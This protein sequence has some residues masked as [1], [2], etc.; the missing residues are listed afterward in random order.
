MVTAHPYN[1][2]PLHIKFFTR[3]SKKA[4]DE[5]TVSQSLPAGMT[6]AEEY[7]GVDGRSGL[8]GSGRVGPVDI[9]DGRVCVGH[10][11]DVTKNHAIGQFS[12]QHM[13][14]SSS[15]RTVLRDPKCVICSTPVKAYHSVSCVHPYPC[16]IHI[17]S[18]EPL[19]VALCPSGDCLAVSHLS[20]LAADFLSSDP[21]HSA[22][23]LPRGGNCKSC[24]S[25]VLW[26]DIIRGCYRRQQGGKALQLEES[27]R[28]EDSSGAEAQSDDPLG[29]LI[30]RIPAAPTTVKPHR[31]RVAKGKAVKRPQNSKVTT[32][33]RVPLVIGSD[34]GGENF[35]IGGFTDL[36]DSE[37][38]V[39]RRP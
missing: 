27:D 29:G 15:L 33:K 37:S 11:P 20:C 19:S 21:L 9:T 7:E 10:T 28:E 3:M 16:P 39:E 35:D 36:D 23:L 8:S 24:R 13:Q 38:E 2:W 1:M 31:T 12:A 4:W 34:S 17:A 6:F 26:G 30:P 5:A 32:T 14:K 18:Q 25:Y 22:G